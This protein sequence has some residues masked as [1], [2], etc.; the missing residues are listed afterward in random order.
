MAF[1]NRHGNSYYY[2]KKRD[3]NRVI[4]EYLGCGEL[5]Y[6]IAQFDEIECEKRRNQREYEKEFRRT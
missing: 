2:R 5:A 3:G 1:E 4:S 6:L